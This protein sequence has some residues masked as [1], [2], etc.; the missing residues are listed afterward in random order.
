[1]K[2]AIIHYWLV[3]MRGGERVLERI[4]DMF[5]DADLYTHVYLPENMSAKINAMNVK[6]TFISKLPSAA[7]LYQSY[8]PLMPRALEQLD[9]RDYDLVI[10]SESGPAKG[11]ITRPDAASLCYCHSPMRYLWDQYHTYHEAAGKLSKLAMPLL[12]HSLRNWDTI[13]A[14]RVD[15]YAANSSFVR[16]RIA[17]F[18][19]RDSQVIFPPV[20]VDEFKAETPEDYYLWVGQL[21]PYKRPDVAIEAFNASGRPLWVVGDGGASE[22]L[23]A[24]AKPNIRFS[25]RL[26]FPELKQAYAKAKALVFT[27]EEDFGI[28]PPEAMASGR[29]VIAYGRGGALETVVEG[30]TGLFYREQTPAALNAA[31]DALEAWLPSFSSDA[32]V[33]HARMFAPEVF[34]KRFGDFVQMGLANGRF[35]IGR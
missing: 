32:C 16:R 24:K 3:S 14:S 25:D 12:M 17:K 8:L 34:D 7:K 29:P 15:H 4:C 26:S 5:P 18:Y 27:A 1:M 13:S 6:T 21:V 35:D 9:L 11:V 31:V 30:K 33:E 22:S 28:V 2:V 20:S 19:G 23:R 10:S